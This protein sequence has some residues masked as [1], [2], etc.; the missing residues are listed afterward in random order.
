MSQDSADTQAATD[1]LEAALQLAARLNLPHLLHLEGRSLETNLKEL[2]NPQA[3]LRMGLTQPM[4][5]RDAL[6]NLM[7]ASG[8][9]N[10]QALF[11]P[12]TR[13]ELDV[14]RRIAKNQSNQEIADGLYISVSTVK[15]H[16]NNLFRKL[17][18]NDR[19]DALRRA[20]D[21]GLP[22]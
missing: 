13:R 21:V 7:P 20:K 4:P 1:N 11:E 16:I 6:I 19:A 15:T 3:R 9:S 10:H 8:T 2:I 5:E 14:L 12:I 22:L 17:D 18:A